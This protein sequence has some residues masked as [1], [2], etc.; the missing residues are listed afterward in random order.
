MSGVRCVTAH[1]TARHSAK[2]VTESGVARREAEL[3]ERRRWGYCL[4]EKRCAVGG[5]RLGL[6]PAGIDAH[7][8]PF[9]PK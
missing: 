3:V 5:V 6:G 8:K 1:K 2:N 9:Q 7:R 4:A